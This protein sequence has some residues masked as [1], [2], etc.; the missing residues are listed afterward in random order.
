MKGISG[1][2]VLSLIL[3]SCYSYKPMK[4]GE[5]VVLGK[6]YQ[7]RSIE[8][9]K[10]NLKIWEMGD[11]IKGVSDSGKRLLIPSGNV[12]EVRRR[13]YS[14]VKTTLLGGSIV[15]FIVLATT[16]YSFGFENFDLMFGPE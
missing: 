1:I 7:I 6:K 15:G 13:K 9:N 3:T 5:S 8:N 12:V 16:D 4:D 2:L 14:T 10:E 11:T